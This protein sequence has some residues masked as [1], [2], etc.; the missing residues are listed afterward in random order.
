VATHHLVR[1]GALTAAAAA[2]L[3]LGLA[4]S[5]RAERP[6][7]Y[8]NPSIIGPA[9][10]NVGDTL[11]ASDGGLHCDP[12]CVAAGPSPERPGIYFE[13]VSCPTATSGGSDAPAGGLP[14]QRRPCPGGV[15]L[16]G[17]PS[18]TATSY[19]VK[20]SDA[21]RW[22]QLHILATNYDCGETVREGPDAGKSECNYSSA[23]GYSTTVGP[24]GGTAAAPP[25]PPPATSGPAGPPNMKT[26]PSTT[27]TAKEGETL[28]AAAGTWT[29][30]PTSYGYQWKRC[31]ANWEPCSPINGA[32]GAT[33]VLTAD[34]VNSRVQ[35]LVTATN[36]KGSNSAASLPTDI[37]ATSAVAPANSALPTIAGILED[38]QTLTASPG[39]WT[40]TQPISYTFQWLRCNTQLNGCAAIEGAT[41]S[42]FELTREDLASRLAVTVTA[43][44]RAGSAFATSATS[45]HVTAAKPRP[46]ADRL[47]IEDVEASNG[48]VLATIKAGPAKV[49]PRGLVTVSVRVTDRRGFLIEGAIVRASG[50]GVKGASGA[51]RATGEVAF[52]LRA[53][54]KLPKS[55]LVLTV[56]VSKPGDSAVT[57]T[58]RVRLAVASKR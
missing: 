49:K 43:T 4:G 47:A 9:Q 1:V 32:T 26:Y 51:T 34:D 27:G 30:S 44:N 11:N 12:G 3:T 20:Q 17:L 41:Q 36:A 21:G 24:V 33:Y 28:T 54:A 40:G 48:L 39:T 7:W 6:G 25:P 55:G 42:T 56:S 52:R 18:K 16:S 8:S 5:A 38:R 57:A 45:T 13:W 23:E 58:K 22:I 50:Q 10:P 29:D 19:A 15:S 35:V 37:V 46:G 31:D 2:I 14:D 53:G